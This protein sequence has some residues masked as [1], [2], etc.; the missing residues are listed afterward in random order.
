MFSELAKKPNKRKTVKKRIPLPL[1]PP[2]AEPNPKAYKR[3]D[4]H[5]QDWREGDNREN[6]KT[7]EGD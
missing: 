6:G 4:K 1:K 3:R 7:R 2:K 5:A